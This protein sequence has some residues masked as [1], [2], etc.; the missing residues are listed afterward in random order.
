MV[1]LNH[2]QIITLESF[3]WGNQMDKRR[4]IWIKRR[5]YDALIIQTSKTPKGK[6]EK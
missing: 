3:F 1:L 6:R 4:T 5:I 2:P